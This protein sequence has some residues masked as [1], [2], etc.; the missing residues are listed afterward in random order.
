M[1]DY[2]EEIKAIAQANSLEALEAFI[3]Q[4]R[5]ADLDYSPGC[6]RGALSTSR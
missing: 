5:E 6:T 2:S 1:P 3:Q 4:Q